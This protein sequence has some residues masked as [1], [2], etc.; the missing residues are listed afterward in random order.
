VEA[1]V[2]AEIILTPGG[3][4]AWLLVGLISGWM[5]GVFMRGFGFGI[6]TDIIVGLI[7]AFLGGILVSFFVEGAAG[8][9]GSIVIAF[10][11]ACL[12][13][14]VVRAVAPPRRT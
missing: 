6:I 2:F 4:I 8:F 11:G 5:A 7:G 13:I 1:T 3:V 10:I 12:L 9:W 14:A